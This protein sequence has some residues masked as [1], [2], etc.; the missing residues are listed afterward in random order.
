MNNNTGGGGSVTQL[1]VSPPAVSPSAGVK[2][3]SKGE[4]GQF[5][6]R[7]VHNG[8]E[9]S[10]ARGCGTRLLRDDVSWFQKEM[11]RFFSTQRFCFRNRWKS[12]PVEKLINNGIFLFSMRERYCKLTKKKKNNNNK[13]INN[14]IKNNKIIK[15]IKIS[16]LLIK[17]T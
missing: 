16:Y 14:K 4:P 13:I 7:P 2:F 8:I 10:R 5:K 15:I 9:N 3:T 6:Q 12:S 17:R 1:R 11:C